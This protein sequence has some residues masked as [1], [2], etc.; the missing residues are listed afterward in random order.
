MG[1]CEDALHRRAAPD[2]HRQEQGDGPVAALASGSAAMNIVIA[3]AIWLDMWWP[4]LL[5]GVGAI[6]V[7][8]LLIVNRLE[9]RAAASKEARR[10]LRARLGA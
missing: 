1:E 10:S 3:A 9:S 6:G 2:S 8:I 4:S 7:V 5:L